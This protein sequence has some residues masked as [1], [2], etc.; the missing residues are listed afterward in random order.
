MAEERGDKGGRGTGM[1]E[2]EEVEEEERFYTFV[3]RVLLDPLP[4]AFG[5]SLDARRPPR[6]LALVWLWPLILWFLEC[7]GASVMRPLAAPPSSGRAPLQ[8][9]PRAVPPPSRRRWPRASRS[10]GVLKKSGRKLSFSRLLGALDATR[11]SRNTSCN[12]AASQRHWA[13][14]ISCPASRELQQYVSS[15]RSSSAAPLGHLECVDVGTGGDCLFHSIAGI[16]ARMVLKGGD[17]ARHVPQ[18]PRLR[19]VRML[20]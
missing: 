17:L 15:F 5:V 9:G 11:A 16:L 8:R 6:S 14:G 12:A 18:K 19:K 10:L 4:G 20:L 1:K 7:G 13:R 3:P 2:E